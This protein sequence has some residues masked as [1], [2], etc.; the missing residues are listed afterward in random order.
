MP[1]FWAAPERPEPARI[2]SGCGAEPAGGRRDAGDDE[3]EPAASRRP[4]AGRRRGMAAARRGR[5]T[6]GRRS[7]LRRVTSDCS[8][9]AGPPAPGPSGRRGGRDRDR[10]AAGPGG[11][12]PGPAG[13]VVRTGRVRGA[14]GRRPAAG[15]GARLQRVAPVRRG[16]GGRGLDHGPQQTR[17]VRPARRRHLRRD[18]PTRDVG[19]RRPIRA[20]E[21]DHLVASPRSGPAV[22]RRRAPTQGPH[23]P[24]RA[25]GGRARIP[26]GPGRSMGPGGPSG[27]LRGPA[28]LGQRLRRAAR[29]GLASARRPAPLAARRAQRGVG[30]PS[31]RERLSGR[32]RPGA[33]R[34]RPR[35]SGRT[36]PRGDGPAGCRCCPCGA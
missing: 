28:A 30:R 27:E 16:R 6:R 29:A 36:P 17:R 21:P 7:R 18:R 8:R 13:P 14:A 23:P 1:T 12:G 31:P 32:S 20:T 11:A 19:R 22:D 34:C 15:R 35:R 26:R 25:R 24:E 4:L 33:V 5:A 2:P 3:P 9:A 10:P